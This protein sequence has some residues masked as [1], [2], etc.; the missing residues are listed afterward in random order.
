MT[1]SID[2]LLVVE[3]SD[4]LR[5]SMMDALAP[6]ATLVLGAE[7]VA[8]ARECLD[9]HSPQ[10]VVVDFALPDGTAFDVLKHAA[11][12]TSMP[13]FVA[14]SG[15]VGTEDAFRLAELGVR[16]FVSKPITDES[17]QRAVDAALEQAPKLGP[18]IRA[19]VGL[20]SI[21]DVEEEVRST[22]VAEALARSDGSK[23]AAARM[24]SIS[25]Q[26]LQHILRQSDD[27]PKNTS[28]S[29]RGE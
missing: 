8:R 7:S 29:R 15:C 6:R 14:V 25:R 24:L 5:A 23:R 19:S 16:A 2:T 11:A 17:L 27:L 18:R 22:M 12:L 20:R 1:S 26:L 21:F 9:Q 28:Q 10:V 13:R 3:D 4:A